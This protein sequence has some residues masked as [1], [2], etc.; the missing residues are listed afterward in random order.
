MTQDRRAEVSYSTPRTVPGD[1]HG[2]SSFML[3]QW[4]WWFEKKKNKNK[5]D[6][7]IKEERLTSNLIIEGQIS[8]HFGVL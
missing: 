8:T 3:S 6:K 7:L 2:G 4:I 5:E 1:E